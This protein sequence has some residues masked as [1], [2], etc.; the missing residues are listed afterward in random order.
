M[1]SMNC[2]NGSVLPNLARIHH[3]TSEI[4]DGAPSEKHFDWRLLKSMRLFIISNSICRKQLSRLPVSHHC[5]ESYIPAEIASFFITACHSVARHTLLF[6]T[7]TSTGKSQFSRIAA[8]MFPS[9]ITST[10]VCEFYCFQCLAQRPTTGDD[11]GFG[12]FV[13][14]L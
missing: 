6:L 9:Q 2:L 4:I 1:I 12:G 7:P 3:F 14:L 5:R 11:G 8:A 13:F 10:W